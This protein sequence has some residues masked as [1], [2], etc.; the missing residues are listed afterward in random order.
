[1]E[2]RASGY[3]EVQVKARRL[4]WGWTGPGAK[5]LMPDGSTLRAPVPAQ[6]WPYG[7]PEGH[8]DCCTL[9]SGGLFCDC[10]ASDASS[11][12]GGDAT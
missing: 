5:D 3:V 10:L 2:G 4:G 11:E 12:E 9:H 8:E 1:M 7:P 6:R